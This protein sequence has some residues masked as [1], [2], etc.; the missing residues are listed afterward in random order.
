MNWDFVRLLEA[1]VDPITVGSDWSSRGDPY[2]LPKVH[3]VVRRVDKWAKETDSNDDLLKSQRN[4]TS[5]SLGANLV[6]KMLTKNGSAAVGLS[7]S[8]TIEVGKRANF[9]M[10][11]RDI[12]DEG[13]ET[14]ADFENVKVLKTWFEGD[15]VWDAEG[16]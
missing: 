4:A 11:D 5:S 7:D 15:L 16:F 9:I 10:L 3:H 2:L 6:L 13:G 12:V 8:G 14:V 1:Q